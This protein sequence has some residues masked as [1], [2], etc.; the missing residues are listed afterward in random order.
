MN[1][2]RL[3]FYT[4]RDCHMCDSAWTVVSRVLEQF[5]EV[6]VKRVDVDASA[7]LKR[8]YGEH[9]PVVLVEGQEIARHR[10]D[11]DLLESALLRARLRRDEPSSRG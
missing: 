6:R 11:P 7:A 3:T 10:V 9:V 1:F 5:G 2:V 4:R 8:K